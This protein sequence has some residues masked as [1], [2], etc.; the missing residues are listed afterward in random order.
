MSPA[1]IDTLFLF[2]VAFTTLS[3]GAAQNCASTADVPP[4]AAISKAANVSTGN[5]LHC[6]AGTKFFPQPIDHS[7]FNGNYDNGS[8]TFL[9]QYS[10]NDT[11]YKPGGPI[12]FFQNAEAPM[13]CVEAT[14]LAEWAPELGA[15]MVIAEHRY[16]G[17]SCPYGL[18]YTEASDWN[19]KLLKDLTLDN[20]FLDAISLLTW[21]KTTAYP[22]AKDAKIIASGGKRLDLETDIS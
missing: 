21:V 2:L 16:F 8:A 3:A 15:L 9:Q 22:T 14:A 18:N 1:L 6:S 7:T 12:L 20:V 13:T 10:I 17:L 5:P 4:S 11:F 19:P